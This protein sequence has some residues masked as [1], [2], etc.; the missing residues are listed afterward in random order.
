MRSLSFLLIILVS[1]FPAGANAFDISADLELELR[2]FVDDDNKDTFENQRALKAHIEGSESLGSAVEFNFSLNYRYD[3]QDPDRKF[4]WSERTA[5]RVQALNNLWVSF[6]TEIFSHGYMEVFN[7]LDIGNAKILDVTPA[8]S[9]KLGELFLSL[10]TVLFDGDLTLSFTPRATEP[11]LPGRD[12]RLNLPQDLN[13]AVW[14]GR[15]GER[16][17]FDDHFILSY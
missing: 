10:Q 15:D 17:H 3:D 6:G 11:L 12:S 2:Q 8:N 5:F 16:D 14:L 9:E 1:L 13:S 7:P 4:F